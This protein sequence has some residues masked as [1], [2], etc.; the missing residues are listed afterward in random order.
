MTKAIVRPEPGAT[1]TRADVRWL[2]NENFARVEC[3]Y[4]DGT[5]A[6]FR[7]PSV[8]IQQV[9]GLVGKAREETWAKCFGADNQV[10]DNSGLR[11][12]ESEVRTPQSELRFLSDLV[13]RVCEG[14]AADEEA[15]PDFRASAKEWAAI[16]R[17]HHGDC[18]H[19]PCNGEMMG[20]AT[21]AHGLFHLERDLA[22][23]HL[24][25]SFGVQVRPRPPAH[26]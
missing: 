5:S 8:S 21:V 2:H 23:A 1:C 6:E 7:L 14:I 16:G 3:D 26:T 20:A 13:C 19:Q 12:R 10:E 18:E 9:H 11:N 25:L 22:A 24:Q 15:P 4:S 17:R